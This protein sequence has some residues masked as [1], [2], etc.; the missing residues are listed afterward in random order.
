MSAD[1]CPECRSGKCQNCDGQTWDV[2]RDERAVC[3]C[4]TNHK[5]K[6]TP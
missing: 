4:W 3:P 1:P 5:P 6:E 2:E